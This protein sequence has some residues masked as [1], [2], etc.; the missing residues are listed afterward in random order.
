MG[1]RVRAMPLRCLA[2]VAPLLAICGLPAA[3]AA[4]RNHF[5]DVPPGHWAYD[6]VNELADLGILV[7]Y[8]SAPRAAGAPVKPRTPAR[9]DAP[10]RPGRRAAKRRPQGTSR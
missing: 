1:Q 10:R 7:G 2:L 6:A 9:G 5:S 4:R 8:P 3:A